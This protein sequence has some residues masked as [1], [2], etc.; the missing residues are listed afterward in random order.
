[1][2]ESGSWQKILCLSRSMLDTGRTSTSTSSGKERQTRGNDVIMGIQDNQVCFLPV[3]ARSASD[4]HQHQGLRLKDL[5]WSF[6]LVGF[7]CKRPAA[8]AHG[9]I[10]TMR[11]PKMQNFMFS[12]PTKRIHLHYHNSS[13]VHSFLRSCRQWHV[14]I[15]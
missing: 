13:R 14:I 3:Q 6:D 15:F 4:G 10:F 5:L 9:D 2:M 1:M 12:F 7:C 11:T 8:C